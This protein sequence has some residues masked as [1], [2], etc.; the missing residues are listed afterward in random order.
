MFPN[1]VSP[2][3]RMF[4]HCCS[5]E[6]DCR[7]KTTG[8][9]ILHY[10]GHAILALLVIGA[11]AVAFGYVVMLTWNAVI[12]AVFNL[13]VISFWQAVG[14]LVLIRILTHRHG[15]RGKH[16]R[17]H[18]RWHGRDEAPPEGGAYAQ[19]WWEEGDA[20]FKAYQS[21]KAA[22]QGE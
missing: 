21:R 13:P 2:D 22:Q 3:M 16:G 20:A 6:R 14:L 10:G 4:R 18:K 19:W 11:V 8:G 5:S 9:R 1:G 15:H 7:P 17:W 12:P